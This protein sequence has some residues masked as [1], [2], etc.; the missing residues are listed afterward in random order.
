MNYEQTLEYLF[1]QL[2][3]FS[4]VGAAAYKADLTNT[5]K[6]CEALGNPQHQFK[7]IHIAGTNGKGSTSHMLA[8]ILQTAGYKTGLYTSPHLVD[9]RERIKIDGIYC[10]KEFVVDFTEKIKPLIEAIQPS[11]FEITVAMAFS[12]FAEQ[13]V[14]IAV[15][16]VGLGGRL[17]ST[18][19]IT[20]EVSVITNIGLDHTQ[21]LGNTIPEIAGEKAGI[22]KKDIPCVISEYTAETRP[23]FDAAASHTSISYAPGVYSIQNAKY[24]HESLQVDLINNVTGAT[25]TYSL[26]LNGSYQAK[27]VLGV[28]TAIDILQT[29]GW[30]ITHENIVSGLSKVKINTGLYGRWQVMG[31]NPTTVV[32]VAH[33]VA[34]IQTLLAQIALLHY[35]QLHL[36][37][38]MVKDKDIDSVLALLPAHATYYFTKAQIERAIDAHELQE[39]AGTYGL[40]GNTYLHVNEAIAAAKKQAQP[41]DLIV[42]CGSVFLVGE[43]E[44]IIPSSEL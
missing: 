44:G 35:N 23:V 34:G 21:F 12:Y 36:V 19:I 27:N 22:I 17:D 39:K 24:A 20:P 9:F 25:N 18:N 30:K 13:K 8:S 3:M 2:P 41:N 1:T 43:I 40:M 4:R 32:D 33:N 14:D 5:I 37:F 7:S 38:G 6:L 42:V 11:F 31:N 16:E 10:S 15:I 26:D 28:L 29:K